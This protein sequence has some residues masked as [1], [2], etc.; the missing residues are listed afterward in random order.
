MENNENLDIYNNTYDLLQLFAENMPFLEKDSLK[1]FTLRPC[2]LR[3]L[4]TKN[5]SLTDFQFYKVCLAESVFIELQSRLISNS[6][7]VH[8]C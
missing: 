3:K 8:I 7:N 2:L 6:L 1:Y 5:I 4:V